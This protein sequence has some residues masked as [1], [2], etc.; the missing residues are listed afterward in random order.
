MLMRT[1]AAAAFVA[2]S[3]FPA[4]AAEDEAPASREAGLAAWGKVFEVFSHPRCANCHVGEDARPRWSGAHYGLAPGEWRRHGMNVAGGESR[5]GVETV[6]CTTC[7]MH[8]N[9]EAPHG[10]PGAEVWALP[11]AEMV[12]WRKSS[13]EICRQVKDPARNGERTLEEIVAHVD[14]DP[15]VAWGWAPG[16]TRAPAPHSAVETAAFLE[17]WARAGAPCPAE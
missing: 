11:P 2:A 1:I 10:P 6:P 9:S 4:F 13:A 14:H 7:H 8:E 15:L 17:T 5:I 16:G 12:W 3:V